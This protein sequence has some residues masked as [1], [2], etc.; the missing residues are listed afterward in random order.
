M[1]QKRLFLLDA[2]ALIYR[3]YYALIRSPRKTTSGINTSAIFGFCN[4][5][6]DLLKKENPDYIAVCFDPPGGH[7]FR[8]TIFPEY[9]AQRDKQPEDI[10]I[11]VPYIKDILNAYNIKTIEIKDVEADDV[12]GT[13]SRMAEK[14]GFITYM[15]TPDKD[16]GQLVTDKVLMYRPA[17][18]GQ[19][20][21]IR[22]VK[23]VCER[24]GIS[25]TR[26]VIDM[27]ALEGDASDN[28]PGC[29]GVG[30]KTAAKLIAEFGSVENLL[31]NT[32]NLKGVLKDKIVENAD[33]IRLSYTL[34]T[35]KTNL[36]LE[37][38]L[39]SLA[40]KEPD[41]SK[42]KDIFTKL[43]FKS[44]L[45]KLGETLTT[46][47]QSKVNDL[48]LPFEEFEV[49]NN[50]AKDQGFIENYPE[51]SIKH[52]E[53]AK[54]I[55]DYVTDV[56]SSSSNY[57]GINLYVS[58]DEAMT[59]E[60]RGLSVYNETAGCA[61]IEFDTMNPETKDFYNLL[62]PLFNTPGLTVI[63]SDIKRD[64][65]ILRRFAIDFTSMK[66]DTSLAHYLLD[67]EGK[68]D[69][70]FMSLKYLGIKS[71]EYLNTGYNKKSASE[72]IYEFREEICCENAR[73]NYLLREKLLQLLVHNGL[74]SLYNT[75]ELPLA[76][77]L[78]DMEYTGVKIDP[79]Q[80]AI[81]SGNLTNRMQELETEAY[82]IAGHPFNISSPMQ[83]G[84]LLFG[85]L[86]IDLTAK[87][88]KKGSWS[89][90]EEILEKY[91]SKHR[92]V[93]LILEIRGLK[94][95]LTTYINALP[96]LINPSTG[97]IHT[98]YNQTVTATGR[99][100]STNPN[101]Q[102]IPIRTEEGREIRKA[103]IP[104]TGNKLIAA[105]YSQIELRLIADL[106]NDTGMIEAFQSGADIHQATAA[107][108]YHIPDDAVTPTQ[109]RNAKTANFGIIYGISAFGLSER[110][111][112]PRSEAKELIDNYMKTYPHIKV[113]MND[114]IELARENKFVT[115]ISGR[116]RFI[117]E[118]DSRNAVVRGYAERNAI[119]API[120]GSAADII[121]KA[122]LDID[123]EFT[124]HELK[125]KMIMQVHDELIFDVSPDEISTVKEIVDRCMKD[126]YH[127]KV[128]L[129]V[130]MGIGDNW[131][132]AH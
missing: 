6:E 33:K 14:K 64:T 27:L 87:K 4:T 54:A 24:Y 100:S 103:F 42:L 56:T 82:S 22:G 116:K 62:T 86:K 48:T 5:L 69:T 19:G 79:R 130:G 115:T 84:E 51:L 34:A 107:K 32:D 9:K 95:L 77:V 93:K 41:I 70:S 96:K 132:Q 127:G 7:T 44:F 106:S 1:E 117:P 46:T 129:E 126:A 57:I 30:E 52:L 98:T 122:M 40:R 110:L 104:S 81:M 47:T 131:F 11:A 45:A 66:F 49:D 123:R 21:E 26:Q 65:I 124:R 109:R 58:G 97:R 12:I 83:V 55:A 68:H 29:P 50:V 114:A 16:Y 2:Y 128:A 71:K 78:A 35:I 8:H 121:K 101:L 10:T 3:A 85:E 36:D 15:M 20:F 39:N 102:N 23:E 99:I 125:T 60:W 25:N 13:L 88:T 76:S 63:S 37:L 73:L 61:F 38:D 75:L 43:E 92:I 111:S 53:T 108:I 112:I 89:T 67:P 118:I 90:T 80:L 74:D 91:A 105:D 119:N 113:Y 94:K 31:E 120:Q 28:I 72:Y 18:K 17:L 59:A